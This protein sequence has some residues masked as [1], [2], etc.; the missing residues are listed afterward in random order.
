[1]APRWSVDSDSEYLPAGF[2]KIGYDADEQ[3]WTYKDTSSGALYRSE[4]GQQ[5]T[6]RRVSEPEFTPYLL[7]YEMKVSEPKSVPR[8][9]TYGGESSIRRAVSTH[10]KSEKRPKRPQRPSHPEPWVSKAARTAHRASVAFDNFASMI[11]ARD[12]DEPA[13]EENT[14]ASLDYNTYTDFTRNN[15][16]HSHPGEFAAGYKEKAETDEKL[17]HFDSDEE[18][19]NEGRVGSM[20]RA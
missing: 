18:T 17:I 10:L 6:V 11:A 16:R 5:F 19:L 15:K 8:R 7:P 1:M 9:H 13:E 4:P 12:R 20:K 3:V 2:V 14:A